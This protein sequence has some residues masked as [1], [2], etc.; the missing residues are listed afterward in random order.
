VNTLAISLLEE[1][2]SYSEPVYM[3]GDHLFLPAKVPLKKKDLDLV[4]MLGIT[5]VYTEGFL[6][7]G[8]ASQSEAFVFNPEESASQTQ[9]IGTAKTTVPASSSETTPAAKELPEFTANSPSIIDLANAES[10]KQENPVHKRL[11]LIIRQLDGIF[12]EIAVPQDRAKTNISVRH[13]WALTTNMLKIVDDERSVCL[14]FILGTPQK[15]YQLAKSSVVATILSILIAQELKMPDEKIPEIAVGALL[16]DIGMLRLPQGIVEKRGKLSEEE[17]A[18]IRTHTTHSYNIL[19]REL[20]YS[21]AVAAIALQHH[22][23][24]DGTGYPYRLVGNAIDTGARI[25]CIA[26]AFEA[27]ICE[28]P[29]RNPIIGYLAMKSLVSEN[30]VHFAPNTLKAFINVMGMYP[31]GSGVALN[32]GRIARVVDV[33][34]NIPLRPVVQVIANN[35]AVRVSGGEIIDL[36]AEKQLFITQ[37]LDISSLVT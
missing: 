34:H 5:E 13:L 25:V 33:H 17:T 29:Y 3:E 19:T 16:H 15:N 2:Q 18:I 30:A 14:G 22:E 26:D 4:A 6:L 35:G 28:K 1:G 32:D 7:I 31:I 24:W 9:S 10:N 21:P 36:L 11:A 27:M 8:T 37:A 12:R 23:R 20:A